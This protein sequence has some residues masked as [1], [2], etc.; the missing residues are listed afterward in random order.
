MKLL[1]RLNFRENFNSFLTS[2]L[3]VDSSKRG[4]LDL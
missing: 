3:N 1:K 4:I 2:N